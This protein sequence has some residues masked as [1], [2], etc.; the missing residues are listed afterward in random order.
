MSAK[1]LCRGSERDHLRLGEPQGLYCKN[2]LES[3]HKSKKEMMHEGLR[4]HCHPT[5]SGTEQQGADP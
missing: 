5:G 1:V 4:P 3:K 2:L